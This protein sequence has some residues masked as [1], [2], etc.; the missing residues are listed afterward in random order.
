[1]RRLDGEELIEIEVDDSLQR[2]AGGTVSQGLGQRIEPLGVL[3]LQGGH[4][5]APALRRKGP[6]D[7]ANRRSTIRHMS[8]SEKRRLLQDLG[9]DLA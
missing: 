2:F 8:P 5:V 6:D 7:P 1:M 4:G 3:A 9:R